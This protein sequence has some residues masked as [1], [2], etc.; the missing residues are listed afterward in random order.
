[1]ED[2]DSILDVFSEKNLKEL[3]DQLIEEGEEYDRHQAELEDC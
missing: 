3:V 2:S 1:V